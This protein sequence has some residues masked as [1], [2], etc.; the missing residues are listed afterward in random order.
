MSKKN[1]ERWKLILAFSCGLLVGWLLVS[2]KLSTTSEYINNFFQTLEKRYFR[3]EEISN[4]LS[5]EYYDKDLL[6]GNE[7]LMIE[8]ATKAFV[9]GL[10]DPYTSYL[11]EEQYSWLQTELEGDDSIEWI[12]AVIW[13]KD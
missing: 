13:K 1:I 10:G 4:L 9:D 11:D 6:T 12:G 2:W 3:M 7:Q 8:K 5:K